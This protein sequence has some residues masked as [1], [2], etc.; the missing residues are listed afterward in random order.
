M[1]AQVPDFSDRFWVYALYDARTDQFGELGKPYGTKPGFYLLAGPNWKGDTPNGVQAVIRSATSLANAVPR[2][3]MDDN[4]EDH[5]AIQSVINQIDIYPLSDFD[6][7]MKTTEW[8]KAPAIPGPPSDAGAGETKWV[9]PEKFFDELGTILD[10]VAP[11]PGEEALYAQ[12][13]ALLD[14]AN[15]NPAIKKILVDTAVATEREVIGPFFQWAHN[16]RPAG[17]G[18]NRS[19]NNAQFGIDYFDR[20]GTAKSNMFEN[21][22]TET[23]YFYTDNDATGAPLHGDRTYKVTFPAGQEPPVKGFW[24]L[25]LL[26]R[27]T[28]VPPQRPQPVLAG[29]Q[30]QEPQTQPRRISDPLRRCEILWAGQRVELA[31]RPQRTVLSLHP[32][33][34]GRTRHHRSHLATTRHRGDVT[35]HGHRGLGQDMNLYRGQGSSS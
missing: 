23:Q 8:A 18:W 34:L 35:G 25:T 16:G 11:L 19:T 2:V 13:R 9:V 4:P 21:R 5:A 28:P 10:Q 14:S 33:L 30:K 22:P 29:H 7:K 15:Q 1:I 26:R 12:F 32:R 20:T 3:F 31:A 17:N 24:S 6:G 27:Q